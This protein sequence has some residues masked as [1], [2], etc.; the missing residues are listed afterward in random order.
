[1]E[2]SPP[3]AEPEK[4]EP[5]LQEV[6]EVANE[7]AKVAA[8]AKTAAEAKKDVQ[9]SVESESEKRGIELSEDDAK[10]IADAT[11]AGL[12][13]RGA[14][15]PGEP[16]PAPNPPTPAGESASGDTSNPT[17]AA[18]ESPPAPPAAPDSGPTK[19]TFAER[20]VGRK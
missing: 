15:E 12:E 17:P 18:P 2:G 7:A 6:Q 8:E 4:K 3:N 9:E 14:F 5:T 11:I 1:M 19:R 13:A 20:F 16:E 10:K